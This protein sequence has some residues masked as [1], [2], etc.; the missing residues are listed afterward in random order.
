MAGIGAK[1]RSESTFRTQ[2]G[3]LGHQEQ[4]QTMATLI[5]HGSDG[6]RIRLGSYMIPRPWSSEAQHARYLHHDLADL[7]NGRLTAEHEAA[8][9]ALSALTVS[10]NDPL[11]CSIG[12]RPLTAAV[13]LRERIV[14]CAEETRRRMDS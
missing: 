8:S 4:G 10:G 13:W 7:S 12:T 11:V 6:L 3:P 1:W 2:T 14:R 9:I 5:T